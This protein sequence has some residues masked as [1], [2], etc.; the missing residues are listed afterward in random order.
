MLL[1]LECSSPVRSVALFRDGR[2]IAEANRDA[3]PTAP[4]FALI[5]SALEAASVERDAL[6]VLAVGVGPGSYTG[7]RA[8][9]AAA[10]GWELARP[11]RL[12]AV[13]SDV[14]CAKTCQ[15][16]GQRGRIAVVLDAQRGELYLS[17]FDLTDGG[18]TEESPLRLATR[19]EATDL[20]ARGVGLAGPELARLGLHGELAVPTAAAVGELA[21]GRCDFL[22]G[23]RLEPVYL[24]PTTFVK[25]PPSRFTG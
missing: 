8:A 11:I 5:Q 16:R 12:L 20:E 2:R 19:S 24:R 13:R 14:A 21:A 10:Q 23:E 7:I 9:I 4:L 17:E 22:S 3:D 18:L 15:S 1:A 6:E 25:A